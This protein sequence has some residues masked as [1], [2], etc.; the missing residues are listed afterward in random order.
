MFCSG[1]EYS[2]EVSMFTHARSQELE[3]IS[4]DYAKLGFAGCLDVASWD[5][6][7]CPVALQRSRKRPRDLACA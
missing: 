6:A 4:N 2:E 5:W 7:N 1:S 3:R